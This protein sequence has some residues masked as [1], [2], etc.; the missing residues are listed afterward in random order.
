MSGGEVDED[1]C[2]PEG[3]AVKVRVCSDPVLCLRLCLDSRSSSGQ[4]Q[5]KVMR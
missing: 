1:G 4:I 2:R 5:H 3:F